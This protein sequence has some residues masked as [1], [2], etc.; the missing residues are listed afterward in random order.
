MLFIK[1]KRVCMN[2]L[3]TS[4]NQVTR[5]RQKIQIV[6]LATVVRLEV[7]LV[8]FSDFF[9]YSPLSIHFIEKDIGIT[10]KA[11]RQHTSQRARIFTCTDKLRHMIQ[12][13]CYAVNIALHTMAKIIGCIGKALEAIGLSRLPVSLWIK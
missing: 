13:S 4:A 10:L 3:M 11:F 9:C 7:G 6:S 5:F 8:C 2:I 1:T 12:R